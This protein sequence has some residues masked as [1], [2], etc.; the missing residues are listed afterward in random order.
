MTSPATIPLTTAVILRKSRHTTQPHLTFWCT[1][2][3]ANDWRTSNSKWVSLGESNNAL[4]CSAV[5]LEGPP[6][7]PLFDDLRFFANL[8]SSNSK[9]LGTNSTLV[10]VRLAGSLRAANVASVHLTWR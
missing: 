10:V 1:L 9:S 2:A 5:M 6:A 8:A 3:V 4:Q 7:A